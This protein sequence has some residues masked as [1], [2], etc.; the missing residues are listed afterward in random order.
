[1]TPR[2]TFK[3]RRRIFDSAEG[4]LKVQED[5]FDSAEGGYFM[6]Q[7]DILCHKKTGSAEGQSAARKEAQGNCNGRRGSPHSPHIYSVYKRHLVVHAL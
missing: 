7:K 4:H 1:M 5:I 2:R 3:I 6:K